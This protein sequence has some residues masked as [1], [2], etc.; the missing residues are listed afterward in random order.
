MILEKKFIWQNLVITQWLFYIKNAHVNSSGNETQ[1]VGVFL[2]DRCLLVI[3][4]KLTNRGPF[5]ARF[6]AQNLPFKQCTYLYWIMLCPI[7]D[8]T[9]NVFMVGC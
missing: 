6:W 5:T 7:P 1:L 8:M 2:E 4:I 3:G 9:Y